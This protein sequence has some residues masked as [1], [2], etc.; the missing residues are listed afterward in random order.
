MTLDDL[1]QSTMMDAP[2]APIMTVRDML[3]WAMRMLC[4][5]GNAWV[6]EGVIATATGDTAIAASPSGADSV[7]VLSF[8]SPARLGFCQT[9]PTSIKLDR[10]PG[11]TSL[12]GRLVVRPTETSPMPEELVGEHADTLRHG[13]LW[14]LLMLPQ[15]WRDPDTA[16]L[17]HRYWVAGVNDAKRLSW[18]GRQAGGSRVTPRRFT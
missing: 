10:D 17:H 5:E 11:V 16:M 8:S 7:R 4:E 9:S 15:P 18:Y 12:E 13:A 1:V 3:R 14:R 6:E 2:E